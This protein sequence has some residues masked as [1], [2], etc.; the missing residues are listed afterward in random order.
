MVKN[1]MIQMF[2]NDC[3]NLGSVVERFALKFKWNLM[4]MWKL[5]EWI[6]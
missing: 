5:V 6:G 2:E 4:H 1:E 3:K